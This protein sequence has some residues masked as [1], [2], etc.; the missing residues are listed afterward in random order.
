[1]KLGIIL[2]LFVL[3]ISIPGMKE[4]FS[5][6]RKRKECYSHINECL[7]HQN[8]SLLL[9][10]LHFSEMSHDENSREQSNKSP[11]RKEDRKISIL[12]LINLLLS[13]FSRR[14]LSLFT[15]FDEQEYFVCFQSS[16]YLM[17]MLLQSISWTWQ[18][19]KLS[20]WTV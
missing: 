11:K 10:F 5:P 18:M 19:Q 6:S 20:L 13:H 3:L 16:S 17:L 15:P 1:M 12:P 8:S 4:F 7:D 2:L 9:C 14:S